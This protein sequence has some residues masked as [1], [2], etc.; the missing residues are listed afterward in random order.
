MEVVYYHKDYDAYQQRNIVAWAKS[1]NLDYI[2]ELHRNATASHNSSGYMSLVKGGTDATDRAIHSAM[3]SLGFRDLGVILRNDLYNMNSINGIVSYMLAEIGFIDSVGDNEIFDKTL[4]IIGAKI[5]E[6]AEATG[7]K[8]LGVICGHGQ[9]DPG[10]CYFG[11][12]EALDVRKIN[13]AKGAA[14]T[15]APT[16]TPKPPEPAK[17]IPLPTKLYTLPEGEYIFVNKNT[18]SVIDCSLG[19]ILYNHEDLHKAQLFQA[20]GSE[21]QKI[22]FDGKHLIAKW[23]GQD[24]ALD[25]TN[26]ALDTGN[27]FCFYPLHVPSKSN[28]EF[29]FVLIGYTDAGYPIIRIINVESGRC[30]DNSYNKEENGNPLT[31]WPSEDRKNWQDWIAIKVG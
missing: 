7:V 30:V 3:V 20:N 1:E 6:A 17:P 16:P 19:G 4:S 2:I 21:R 10:A 12:Q 14:P 25:N 28:Q 15:P 31:S 24:V 29:V 22:K 27:P 11:R 5:F 23:K 8:K 26:H 18:G 13:V 9:G